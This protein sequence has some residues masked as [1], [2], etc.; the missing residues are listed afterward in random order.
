MC[1]ILF[2]SPVASLFPEHRQLTSHSGDCSIF[3]IT[4]YKGAKVTNL[5]NLLFNFVLF[6]L[7]LWCLFLLLDRF[8]PRAVWPFL[9]SP[10]I[11]TEGDCTQ[12]PFCGAFLVWFWHTKASG[13]TEICF[14]PVLSEKPGLQTRAAQL[15]FQGRFSSLWNTNMKKGT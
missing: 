14:V 11:L 9:F 4:C 6:P 12:A 8:S 13:M 5:P 2:A 15:C 3:P 10:Q 7:Y 1:S